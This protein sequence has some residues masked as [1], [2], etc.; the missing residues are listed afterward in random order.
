MPTAVPP[1]PFAF[2]TLHSPA[3]ALVESADVSISGTVE[4]VFDQ[5]MSPAQR[6]DVPL[7]IEVSHDAGA[8]WHLPLEGG[9]LNPPFNWAADYPIPTD[10]GDLWRVAVSNSAPVL[11]GHYLATPQSGVLGSI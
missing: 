11:N 7:N 3:D 1:V 2:S 10:P 9:L 5:A 8:T 6:G 4:F